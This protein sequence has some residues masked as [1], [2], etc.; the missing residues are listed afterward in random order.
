MLIR[1]SSVRAKMAAEVI[2]YGNFDH[3][4]RRAHRPSRF[5]GVEDAAR[6]GCVLFRNVVIR[7]SRLERVRTGKRGRGQARNAYADDAGLARI[8]I[9][10]RKNQTPAPQTQ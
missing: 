2:T 7:L 6:S 9:Y 5:R 3:R 10:S 1:T 4:A 8:P